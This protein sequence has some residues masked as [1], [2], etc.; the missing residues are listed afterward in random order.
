VKAT[1]PESTKCTYADSGQTQAAA[2]E[3]EQITFVFADYDA[4]K[5]VPHT[6]NKKSSGLYR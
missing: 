6:G 3:G 4:R 5:D 1:I 2:L